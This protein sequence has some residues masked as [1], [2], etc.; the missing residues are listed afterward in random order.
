MQPI[1]AKASTY[2]DFAVESNDTI[3]KLKVDYPVIISK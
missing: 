1:Q 3:P 2:I